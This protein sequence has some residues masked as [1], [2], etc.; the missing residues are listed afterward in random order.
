[1]EKWVVEHKGTEQ[2]KQQLL[3]SLGKNINKGV[4]FL[5]RGTSSKKPMTYGG[6]L[7]F[8]NES[9]KT[10][11]SFTTD[12]RIAFQ[13]AAED[14]RI[15]LR[16]KVP[17]LN[18]KTVNVAA[19]KKYYPTKGSFRNIANIE[20]EH[21][22]QSLQ[23]F[24][25]EITGIIKGVPYLNG[26][27]TLVDIALKSKRNRPGL[28]NLPPEAK[29]IIYGALSPANIRS[30]RLS[31]KIMSQNAIKYV[32]R[33]EF[34]MI[35]RKEGL[36]LIAEDKFFQS[37]KF[38]DTVKKISSGIGATVSGVLGFQYVQ[39]YDIINPNLFQQ[40]ALK[41]GVL[42]SVS[43]CEYALV[44]SAAAVTGYVASVTGVNMYKYIAEK[45]AENEVII[46]FQRIQKESYENHIKE[47]MC[48]SPLI[49]GT[50]RKRA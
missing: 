8:I 36:K 38:L 49:Q 34:S 29:N 20:Q 25:I 42:Q 30:L 32:Y 10:P 41:L 11:R 33:K 1:L 19:F 18:L 40:I 46:E 3:N 37:T 15:I 45:T 7:D 17:P 28:Q 39:S 12:K 31:C 35:L 4:E 16:L 9:L 44:T 26:K 2:N 14:N 27:Y 43:T 47:V 23:D 48:N 24:R 50:K 5:Y 22:V 13:F 6:L 21:F